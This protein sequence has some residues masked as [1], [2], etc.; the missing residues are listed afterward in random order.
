MEQSPDLTRIMPWPLQRITTSSLL[1]QLQGR[2]K[3]R[4]RKKRYNKKGTNL[5][6]D[7]PQKRQDKDNDKDRTRQ[8]IF[9]NTIKMM[10]TKAIHAQ[11]GLTH[12]SLHSFSLR[13]RSGTSA[14]DS[15]TPP[16]TKNSNYAPMPWP[17]LRQKIW[18]RK[19]LGG[20]NIKGPLSE[21]I[22]QLPFA[23]SNFILTILFNFN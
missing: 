2:I 13:H 16:G 8:D 20:S 15:H 9:T 11:R 22:F 18:K 3:N 14:H 12:T 23:F 7:H 21:M 10:K 4:E 5:P 6:T 19:L 17:I 1:Q